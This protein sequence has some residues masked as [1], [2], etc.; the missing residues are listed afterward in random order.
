[1][2]WNLFNFPVFSCTVHFHILS[3]NH[4]KIF[5]IL[6]CRL[7]SSTSK[8]YSISSAWSTL[9][10]PFTLTNSHSS[11]RIQQSF[12]F[13]LDTFSNSS[14]NHYPV[15]CFNKTLSYYFFKKINNN[16]CIFLFLLSLG[17]DS[18]GTVKGLFV[19]IQ[20]NT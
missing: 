3:L 11:F 13:G 6:H 15:I 1:M 14:Y 2:D 9:S 7:S 5:A 16:L 8:S 20:Y 17:E 19:L 4:T 10:T 12:P 18:S